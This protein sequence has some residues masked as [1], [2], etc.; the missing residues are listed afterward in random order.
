MITKALYMNEIRDL[1]NTNY[2]SVKFI[3]KVAP[4]SSTVLKIEQ[5]LNINS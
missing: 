5:L 4:K 3:Y 1:I 2:G